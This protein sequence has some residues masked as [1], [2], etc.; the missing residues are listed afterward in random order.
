MRSCQEPGRRGSYEVAAQLAHL[1]CPHGQPL[2]SSLEGAVRSALSPPHG[3]DGFLDVAEQIG[4]DADG[5]APAYE[6]VFSRRVGRF[7]P[8]H[9]P[10]LAA[11]LWD[12]HFGDF[13]CDELV[14]L[15][16]DAALAHVE[17]AAVDPKCTAGCHARTIL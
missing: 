6:L 7:A 4:H 10:R 14:E 1:S 11:L 2:A 12:P 16:T 15:G 3:P 5:W 8:A 13:A 9:I 17:Q